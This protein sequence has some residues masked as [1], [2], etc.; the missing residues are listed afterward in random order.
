MCH[1]SDPAGPTTCLRGAHARRLDCTHCHGTLEDHALSLLKH[2]DGAGKPGARRLMAHLTARTVP[3]EKQIVGRRPWVQEPDCLNCHTDAFTR[4]DPA[5]VSAFNQWT[6]G[7]E[8]LYRMRTDDTGLLQCEACHGATH[9]LYPATNRWFGLD[10][11]N[12]QPLQYQG[13]RRPIGAGG[14]CKV[15]HTVEMQDSVHHEGMPGD[16]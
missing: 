3:D 15:C 7:L 2:E 6:E 12:L 9:A 16:G 8:E 14:N 5:A 10:R 13:N 4:P 11:D 1:P